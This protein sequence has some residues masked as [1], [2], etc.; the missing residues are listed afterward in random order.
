[1]NLVL[2]EEKGLFVLPPRFRDLDHAP[3]NFDDVLFSIQ[4][5]FP[6]ILYISTLL[7]WDKQRNPSKTFYRAGQS[8]EKLKCDNVVSAQF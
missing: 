5:C 1:M 6:S 2:M 7:I 8:D 4:S 3:H